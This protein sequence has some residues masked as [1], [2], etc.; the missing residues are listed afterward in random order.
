MQVTEVA[1]ARLQAE[2]VRINSIKLLFTGE[3]VDSFGGFRS[4]ILR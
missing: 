1:P 4:A 3:H 2:I